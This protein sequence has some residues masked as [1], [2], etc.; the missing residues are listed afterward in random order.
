MKPGFVKCP[1][2][3]RP[4]QLTTNGFLK[5]HFARMYKQGGGFAGVAQKC[6]ASGKN[7]KEL[8]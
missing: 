4:V 8:T 7:L 5:R 2:C 1:W 6:A 3:E